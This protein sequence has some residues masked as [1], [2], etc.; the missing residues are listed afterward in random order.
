MN[1]ALDLRVNEILTANGLDFT[2]EKLPMIAEQP[3]MTIGNSGLLEKGTK[4][5]HTPYFGLLNSKT[6][7]V[8]N[9]VKKGYEVS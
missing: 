2:I 7:E 8:I 9:T 4:K 3:I 1:N 6:G 5:V